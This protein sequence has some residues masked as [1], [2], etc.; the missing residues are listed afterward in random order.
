[1]SP[2][3]HKLV[4]YCGQH[5]E[6]TTQQQAVA[7]QNA[8]S[9]APM[10]SMYGMPLD[11]GIVWVWEMEQLVKGEQRPIPLRGHERGVTSV[12][13]SRDS[14]LLVT[15][16]EDYTVRIFD[17]QSQTP[18]VAQM[19]LKGHEAEVTC[20]TIAPD[21][22]WVASGDRGNIV[23]IWD[24]PQKNMDNGNQYIGKFALVGHNGWISAVT[25]SPDGRWLVSAGY[26][27]SIRLWNMTSYDSTKAPEQGP[28]LETQNAAVLSV[29]FNLN[30]GK[31][32]A[33]C[34]DSSVR[35]WD[36]G[37]VADS[38]SQP[39]ALIESHSIKSVLLQ[40]KQ[41]EISDYQLTD[42]D[43][44]LVM[45]CNKPY[46]TSESRIQLWPLSPENTRKLAN[47]YTETVFGNTETRK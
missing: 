5:N 44:W 26:D 35:I 46:D 39:G 19:V 37:D 22:S 29:R 11:S 4:A 32:V 18:G 33:H 10:N 7:S 43:Q 23:R 8:T 25:T 6:T 28:V 20:V 3:G 16:S 1:M 40:D 36:V 31:L 13:I 45:A 12:A 34:G 42:D 14:K 30:G 15:G 24:L 27:H 21:N 9:N 2:D 38:W 47:E 17:L 41:M